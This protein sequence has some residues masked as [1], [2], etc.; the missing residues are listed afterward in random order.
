MSEHPLATH[1]VGEVVGEVLEE[2]GEECDV[3][4]LF[5]SGDHVGA[6]EEIAQTV[7][8]VLRP[9]T[10][11]GTSTATVLSGSQEMEGRSVVSVWAGAGVDAQ[12]LRMRATAT[13]GP[14]GRRLT[15]L[16]WPDPDAEGLSA[17][18]LLVDPFSFPADHLLDHL[19]ETLPGVPVVG[20]LA[21]AGQRPGT[22][23]LV[24]DNAVVDGG[25][26]GLL[27]RNV[28][29]EAVVSQGCRPVGDAWVVT[30]SEGNE[31]RTLGGEPPVQRL[32]QIATD[33]TPDQRERLARSLQ[34]GLAVNEQREVHEQGEFVI[35]AVIAADRDTGSL[36]VGAPVPVGTLMQF[37]MRD[38][39]AATEDLHEVL[40]GR[41][42][43]GA[44]VFTC[45]GRGSAMF[46]EPNHDAGAV[47]GALGPIPLSGMS[48]AGEIGPVGS[49]WF[50]HGF[51]ASLL[52]VGGA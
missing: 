23:R 46:G 17:V 50:L 43:S 28:A 1:A 30:E 4:V 29:V 12:S 49:R 15:L 44:L 16:G 36:T 19:G 11:I 25:A 41:Q 35:R 52:L 24:V 37:Q 9:K 2:L 22:N 21:S 34:V 20:G 39:D 14:E 10:L 38:P 32:E 33:M 47:T 31:V 45:N 48:C 26:V 13:D 40:A 42:A 5:V 51:T 18:V 6:F 8:L 27:L 7:R 3:A